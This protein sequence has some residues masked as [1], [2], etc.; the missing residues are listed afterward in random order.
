MVN[1]SLVLCFSYYCQINNCFIGLKQE[2]NQLKQKN[3]KLKREIKIRKWKLNRSK[4][5][6]KIIKRKQSISKWL[7]SDTQIKSYHPSMVAK[8]NHN[9][10]VQVCIS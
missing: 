3:Y 6:H 9:E 1:G 4:R 2:V 5:K 8:V 7:Q 10:S